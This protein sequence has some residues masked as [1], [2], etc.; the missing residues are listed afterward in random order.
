MQIRTAVAFAGLAVEMVSERNVLARSWG[1]SK[2]AT[3][4]RAELGKLGCE[5]SG[6]RPPR[7]DV[8]GADVT[9][10]R[11]RGGRTECFTSSLATCVSALRRQIERCFD[12]DDSASNPGDSGC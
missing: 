11:A 1:G 5:W 3:R 9:G 8:G 7:G 12:G 2:P 4:W 10:N 6:C